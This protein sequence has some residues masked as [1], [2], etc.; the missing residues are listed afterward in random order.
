MCILTRL[1][2]EKMIPVISAAFGEHPEG[3]AMTDIRTA[4]NARGYDIT[5]ERLFTIV[6]L[7][8]SAGACSLHIKGG[9]IRFVPAGITP[10]FI[11]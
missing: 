9:E 4:L 11:H 7:F 8:Q 1:E 6:A 10:A 3:L 5:R 2:E